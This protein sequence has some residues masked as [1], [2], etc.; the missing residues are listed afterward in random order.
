MRLPTTPGTPDHSPADLGSRVH[1]RDSE[2]EDAYTLVTSAEADP[3]RGLISDRSP[4][5]RALLGRRAGDEVEVTTPGGVRRLTVLG[6]AAGGVARDVPGQEAD[7][8][9]R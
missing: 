2:G 1:V 7:P 4:V 9:P 6:I 5:G 3:T 8:C